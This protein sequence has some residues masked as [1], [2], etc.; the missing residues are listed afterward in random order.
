[1]SRGNDDLARIQVRRVS[2]ESLAW[3]EGLTV[4]L[5]RT[6]VGDSG[7]ADALARGGQLAVPARMRTALGDAATAL[8][9]RA[10]FTPHP[11]LSSKL[12]FSYR[13]VPAPIR[14]LAAVAIGRAQRRRAHQWA[15]FPGWPLDLSADFLADLADPPAASAPAAP[16]PVVLTHDIDS[17]EGLRALVDR[18]LPIEE[19]A[20]ARSTSYVVPCAW[21]LDEG[22]LEE[23]RARGHELGIHGYDHSNL[24][25][26]ASP[27]ERRVRLDAARPLVERYGS[28]G[29]RAPSLLR[30]EAL[31]EDLGGRYRYDSSIPTSG[32]LFPVP[33]NGCATA[34]PFRIGRM[35]E[36]PITLPRDGSLRFLG[37]GP[38]EI[39][40]LWISCARTI[41]RARGIVVLL[42][43]CES[44]FSGNPAMLDV[45]S[46]FLDSLGGAGGFTWQ[47]AAAVEAGFTATA[48]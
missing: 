21:P 24:T 30:T 32:G 20:G 39:L 1:V 25:P 7:L 38:R 14:S 5:P 34:R 6:L 15:A 44:R 13:H 16:A 31:L 17:P 10:A 18:F 9:I 41:R 29:Y 19:A 35:L 23:I 46:R 48:P 2:P 12:P 3:A 4:H 43:H 8:R 27:A 37:Y 47:T 40:P 11:P 22:L 45:Y 28:V 42:T 36:I 33:N 26:F